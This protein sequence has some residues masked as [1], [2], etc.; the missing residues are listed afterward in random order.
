MEDQSV[1]WAEYAR[2]QEALKNSKTSDD[3]HW[4]LEY[5]LN[6][7]LDDIQKK[8]SFNRSDVE[9]RIKTG[10]RR[11]RYRSRLLRLQPITWQPEALN[12]IAHIE[13]RSGLKFLR[14]HLEFFELVEQIAQGQKYNDLSA[15]HRI[16]PAVLRKRVSR[17]KK[18]AHASFQDH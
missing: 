7:T 16:E 17:A 11:N 12:P 10:A 3:R 8:H 4:G 15:L 14:R 1:D 2:A 5:A 18:R 13:A 9:R 6:K